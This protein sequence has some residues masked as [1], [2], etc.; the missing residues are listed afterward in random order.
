M[1]ELTVRRLKVV[2]ASGAVRLILTGKPVPEGTIAGLKVSHP[3]DP[4]QAAGLLFYNDQGNEQGGLAYSGTAGAQTG[5]LSF[6]AW[7]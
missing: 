1:D 3:G 2:D 7:Q 5:S 4:R 6:D